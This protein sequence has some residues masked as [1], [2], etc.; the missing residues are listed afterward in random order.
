MLVQLAGGDLL[1]V[2]LRAEAGI[3]VSVLEPPGL[4]LM[5]KVR[6][7]G[8]RNAHVRTAAQR[9]TL[10]DDCGRVVGVDLAT[11]R[12]THDTRL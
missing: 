12:G 1:A 4:R 5:A 6:L 8:A 10:V 3:E 9:V 11:L 2:A 7:G